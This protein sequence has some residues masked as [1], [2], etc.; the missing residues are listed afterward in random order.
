MQRIAEKNGA[1]ILDLTAALRAVGQRSFRMDVDPRLH[2]IWHLSEE[3]H[4]I[5][6]RELARTI[7]GMKIAPSY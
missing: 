4:A 6:A 2:D 1:P 5:A 3:G 7:D